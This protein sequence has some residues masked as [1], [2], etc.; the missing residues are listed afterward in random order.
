MSWGERQR[1]R[2]ELELRTFG[3]FSSLGLSCRTYC[4]SNVFFF[5]V[6]QQSSAV[7]EGKPRKKSMCFGVFIASH[8]FGGDKEQMD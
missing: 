2:S 8:R 3:T 4:Y 1:P 6:K 5:Q 7:T